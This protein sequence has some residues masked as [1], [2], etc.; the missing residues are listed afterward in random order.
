M[1]FIKRLFGGEPRRERT[2]AEMRDALKRLVVPELRAAGYK[3]SLPHLRR[4][5]DDGFDLLTFQFSKWGGAFCIEAARCRSSGIDSPLGHIPGE[6]AKAWDMPVR[7]RVGAPQRF[8]DHWFKFENDDPDAVA[9]QAL[10][11]VSEPSLWELVDTF[12][13]DWPKEGPNG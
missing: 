5:R 9:R 8:G 13:K 1:N 7:Q 3:G 11:K 6:K 12:T 10:A 2:G 4:K